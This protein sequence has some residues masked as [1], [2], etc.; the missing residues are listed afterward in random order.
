LNSTQ[1]KYARER[2]KEIYDTRHQAV[3][4]R[5][6][7]PAI[8][9]TSDEKLVALRTG[10]FEVRAEPGRYGRGRTYLSDYVIFPA[11]RERSVD[12]KAINI[13]VAALSAEY[14][15]LVEQLVLGDNAEA[16]KLL[17]KFAADA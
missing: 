16:L 1:V 11:E 9:L 2:A 10:E 4:D 13:E 17:S 8:E 7:T 14:T 6:T 15:S 3:V 12:Q 5:H